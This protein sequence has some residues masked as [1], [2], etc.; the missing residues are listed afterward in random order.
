M[1]RAA[2]RAA[3]KAEPYKSTQVETMT[4]TRGDKGDREKL[5]DDE[6]ALSGSQLR[7]DPPKT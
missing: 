2:F 5:P 7:T 3:G 1:V 4:D 6:A